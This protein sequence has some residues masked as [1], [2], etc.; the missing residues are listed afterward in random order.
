MKERKR[1]EVNRGDD[2][3]QSYELVPGAREAKMTDEG[4]IGGRGMSG[5]E[6]SRDEEVKG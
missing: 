1:N 2:G 3:G 5:L 6:G 4:G